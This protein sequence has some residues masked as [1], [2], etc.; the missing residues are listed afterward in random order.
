LGRG[1]FTAVKYN[2]VEMFRILERRGPNVNKLNLGGLTS[3]HF[4]VMDGNQFIT[5]TLL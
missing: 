1:N 4:A 3:I 2:L 5:E